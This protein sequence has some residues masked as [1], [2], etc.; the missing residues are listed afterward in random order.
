MDHQR[1]S[2]KHKKKSKSSMARKKLVKNERKQK[3]EC[4]YDGIFIYNSIGGSFDQHKYLLYPKNQREKNED[5]KKEKTVRV[6][7]TL[8]FTI[9]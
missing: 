3:F 7:K 4:F 2:E 9:N 1:R 5:I 6:S 8:I